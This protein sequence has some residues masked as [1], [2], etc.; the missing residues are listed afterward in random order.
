MLKLTPQKNSLNLAKLFFKYEQ[1][2]NYILERDK[3][4]KYPK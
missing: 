4:Y 1:Y 3:I 2:Y